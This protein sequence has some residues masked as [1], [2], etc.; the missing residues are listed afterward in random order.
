MSPSLEHER[1]ADA[2]RHLINV[3]ADHFQLDLLGTGSTTFRRA[4]LQRGFEP[5][6][7]YYLHGAAALRGVQELDLN[8]HPPPELVVE[9]DISRSSLGKLELYHAIGVGEVWRWTHNQLV[10]HVLGESGYLE[11]A[12]SQ[13]FPGVSSVSLTELVVNFGRQNRVDWNRS[14]RDWLNLY[15]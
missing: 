3:L 8:I 9:I 6:A 1:T 10:I 2:I 12:E 11:R 13:I 7:S 15:R 4:D 5:D 14:L